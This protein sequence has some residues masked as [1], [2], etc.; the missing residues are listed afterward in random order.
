MQAEADSEATGAG[1]QRGYSRADRRGPAFGR[2][3]QWRGMRS[4]PSRSTP[5]AANV[6]RSTAVPSVGT[7]AHHRDQGGGSA[8]KAGLRRQSSQNVLEK[9]VKP[10]PRPQIERRLRLR[11]RSFPRRRRRRALRPPATFTVAIHNVTSTAAGG[12]ARIAVVAGR[13]GEWIKSPEGDFE[14]RRD[15]RLES[16]RKQSSGEGIG[17]ATS[18]R[19]RFR[20]RGLRTSW[21]AIRN[22]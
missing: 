20:G 14:V 11:L 9:A 3:L 8:N 4:L 16:E 15:E 19:F 5:S 13:F 18:G 10:I 17:C 2:H 12:F 6:C 1:L 21:A 7:A 22:Q